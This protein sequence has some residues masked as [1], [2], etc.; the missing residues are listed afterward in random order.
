MLLFYAREFDHQL[1]NQHEGKVLIGGR[2]NEV[3]DDS[4]GR[5]RSLLPITR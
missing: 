1:T 2:E 3:D 5:S 4:P